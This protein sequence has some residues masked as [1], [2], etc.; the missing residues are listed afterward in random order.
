[1]GQ[2]RITIAREN[3]L[4]SRTHMEFSGER[5]CGFQISGRENIFVEI[6]LP[7]VLPLLTSN[8]LQG[9]FRGPK[10]GRKRPLGLICT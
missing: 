9:C 5:L 7:S 3:D 10:F 8:A 2:N 1:M 4:K 6:P